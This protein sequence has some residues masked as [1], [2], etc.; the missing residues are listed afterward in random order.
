M[1]GAQAPGRHGHKDT[2][3]PEACDL[4]EHQSPDAQAVIQGEEK[5]T[6]QPFRLDVGMPS[7]RRHIRKRVNMRE[8]VLEDVL[9]RAK[10]DPRIPDP[11]FKRDEQ[12]EY[13]QRYTPV[14]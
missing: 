13:R 11:D 10:L 6:R 3:E 5:E 14:G 8:A 4:I 9:A 7:I 1:A 12:N 2:G